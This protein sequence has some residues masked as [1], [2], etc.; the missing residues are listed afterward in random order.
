M[1]TFLAGLELRF[2]RA[3][4]RCILCAAFWLSLSAVHLFGQ[5][6]ALQDFGDAPLPYP[7]VKTNNGAQHTI[8]QGF[9]L[10]SRE[11]AEADGQPNA[12]ALGDDAPTAVGP[13][14]EDGVTFVTPLLA[15]QMATVNVVASEIGK[16]D[17]WIDFDA[18]GSW[19]EPADQ[20]FLNKPLVAGTNVLTFTVPA[21]A[22]PG[23]TFA[24]FRLS[25]KGGLRFDGPAPDGEVE[26]YR[27]QI[28]PTQEVANVT[29]VKRGTPNPVVVGRNLTYTLVVQNNGPAPASNVTVAD[30]LPPN[31][32]YVSA[33]SS[34]GSCSQLS[35]TVTCALGNISAGATASITIIGIPTSAILLTNT[36]CV[37][38]TNPDP[39]PEN[40]CAKILT[41][42]SPDQGTPPCDRTNK[43]TNFWLT[44]PGNY[45]PNPANP[46]KITLCVVGPSG[47][48]GLVRIPGLP[49]PF[50]TNFT[51]PPPA[52]GTIGSITVVLPSAADLASASDQVV[53]KGVN[54]SASNEVAIFGMNHVQFTTDSFL[55]LPRNALGQEYVVAGYK[56]VQSV[57]NLIGTQFALVACEADTLVTITPSVTTGSRAA[58]VPYTITLQQGQAYQLRNTNAVADLSGTIIT[59]TKPVAV[60]GGHSCANIQSSTTFFCDT[61]LEQLLPV[62][63]WGTEFATAPLATR[64]QYAVRVVAARDDTHVQINSTPPVTPSTVTLNRGALFE[65]VVTGPARITADQPVFVA[66]FSGS[67]DMD[68]IVNSDPFMVTIPSVALFQKNYTFCVPESDFPINYANVV[69]DTAG[70][71]APDLRLDGAST[72]ALLTP[73]PASAGASLAWLQLPLSPGLHTLSAAIPFTAIVYGFAEYDSYAHLVGM[74][75]GCMKECLS[76]RCPTNILV[77]S[78]DGLGQ[79]VNFRVFATNSCGGK[80]VVISSPPSGSSF[81]LGTT[82]VH[83]EASDAAGSTVGCSF[84]VTVAAAAIA[85]TTSSVSAGITLIWP[86]GGTLQ[87]AVDLIGPFKTLTNAT[88]PY[89]IQPSAPG[90]ARQGFFRVQF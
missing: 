9:H 18:N 38:A 29:I 25:K 3:D 45:A 21:S 32:S 55:A 42:V 22:H 76:I 54:V 58:G 83:C 57:M 4:V 41:E 75:P 39:E 70:G 56:N 37:S 16:L 47:T 51:I 49:L 48:T 5:A 77:N 61:L 20:I 86:A 10:G 78:T 6:A 88:S 50:S 68:G 85:I 19:A 23:F 73:Y 30:T 66:Q 60:F 40:N 26:D 34:Q 59:A 11:D 8:I 89:V 74:G 82:V 44:F 46:P 24:R 64:S 67:S 2:R 72:T 81:P 52:V 71:A 43:G 13:G 87:T 28:G 69:V 53:A 36:A 14:D 84:T 35:G 65:W 80:A 1:N 79:R 17:A 63:L 62:T 33:N 7:T 12:N 27:V 31:L 15:G 90:A